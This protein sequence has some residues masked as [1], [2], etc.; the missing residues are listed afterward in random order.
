MPHLLQ[1]VSGVSANRA[2]GAHSKPQNPLK[3]TLPPAKLP[4]PADMGRAHPLP[5]LQSYNALACHTHAGERDLRAEPAAVLAVAGAVLLASWPASVT[6]RALL[7]CALHANVFEAQQVDVRSNYSH[8]HAPGQVAIAG[9]RQQLSAKCQQLGAGAAS[10]PQPR[11]ARWAQLKAQTVSAY[12]AV[13]LSCPWPT[14]WGG[15]TPGLAA[16]R[17][18]GACRRRAP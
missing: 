4:A 13:L 9:L 1:T 17:S 16:W 7:A 3:T 6:L 14:C 10:G 5:V 18:N 11:G 12:I 2:R 8:W 15:G